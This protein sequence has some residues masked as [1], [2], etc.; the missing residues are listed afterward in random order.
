MTTGGGGEPTFA[1]VLNGLTFGG[2]RGQ[3]RARDANGHNEDEPATVA[4]PLPN[5]STA[6][7]RAPRATPA[8]LVLPWLDPRETAITPA[9]PPT[10]GAASAYGVPSPGAETH[11]ATDNAT[12]GAT[13]GPAEN[14]PTDPATD[15]LTGT[16]GA[17]ADDPWGPDAAIVR[18]YAWTRGRTRSSIELRVE[19]LVSAIGV[20]GVGGPLEHRAIAELCQLPHSVAEI[21]ALLRVPLGVAKVLVSDMAE[22]GQLTVHGAGDGTQA[23][24]VLMERVLSGLRRL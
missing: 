15:P 23:H 11:A 16:A 1:D 20:P 19:T 4:L 14:R 7:T 18:P 24:F 13:V 5:G 6:A 10:N 12:N 9:G 3:R 22:T 2:R 8:D 21:A 17:D